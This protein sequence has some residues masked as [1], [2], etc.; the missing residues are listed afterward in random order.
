[1]NRR[2]YIFDEE[3]TENNLYSYKS[4]NPIQKNLK[5]WKNIE[6]NEESK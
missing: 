3:K 2:Q 4:Y 1:M 5:K 6:D